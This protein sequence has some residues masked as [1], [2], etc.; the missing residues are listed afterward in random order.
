MNMF[1]TRKS[2][3]N[4]CLRYDRL[5]LSPATALPQQITFFG[6]KLF[7]LV[8][9]SS[10]F[11]LGHRTVVHRLGWQ[12]GSEAP[13]SVPILCCACRASE[14][15]SCSLTDDSEPD[16][17]AWA[18]CRRCHACP[19]PTACRKCGTFTTTRAV[20]SE[21]SGPQG[22]SKKGR[23]RRG[24]P[25][26]HRVQRGGSRQ[27]AGC[28]DGANGSRFFW[29]VMGQQPELMAEGGRGGQGGT[30]GDRGGQGGTGRFMDDQHT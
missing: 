14:W 15:T 9:A 1:A 6:L 28:K 13:L 22:R 4:S 19:H 18:Q 5:R 7:C 11:K 26:N 8:H 10:G 16:R 24:E 3:R 21:R 2:K 25:R 30:G 17:N 23:G 12:H 27:N 20:V 29:G